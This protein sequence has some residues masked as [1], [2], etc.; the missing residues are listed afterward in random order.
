MDPVAELMAQSESQQSSGMDHL[1]DELQALIAGV[2]G[3]EQLPPHI[4]HLLS[5]IGGPDNRPQ[6][7]SKTYVDGLKRVVVDQQ[8]LDDLTARGLET[9]TLCMDSFA[10]GDVVAEL[11]G[12]KPEDCGHWFHIGR[13]GGPGNQECEGITKWLEKN[14]TCPVCRCDLPVAAAG[15]GWTCGVC[16]T[17]NPSRRTNCSNCRAAR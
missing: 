1:P 2:G 8:V 9:C 17:D 5:S 10:I 15:G 4:Q 6:S 12:E 14:N 13:E 3:V 16:S 7:T 11:T